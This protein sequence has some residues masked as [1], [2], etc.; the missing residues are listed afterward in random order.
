M[1]CGPT[2]RSTAGCMVICV[3]V[4]L[5]LPTH[6]WLTK[7][8]S[9]DDWHSDSPTTTPW[10]QTAQWK[11]IDSTIELN[12]SHIH[13]YIYRIID[14][15]QFAVSK[16]SMLTSLAHIFTLRYL[17]LCDDGVRPG[18]EAE[19]GSGLAGHLPFDTH[20]HTHRHIYTRT[21]THMDLKWLTMT[22]KM[23]WP[24]VGWHLDKQVLGDS[25][26]S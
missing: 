5:I 15:S 1:V 19:D 3:R 7:L 2:F 9:Q 23:S 22:T 10:I 13:I 26:F 8:R 25:K 6:L 4:A 12:L 16:C 11:N 21:H 24:L 14:E 20:P 18:E 17:P